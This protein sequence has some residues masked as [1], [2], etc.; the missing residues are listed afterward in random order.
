MAFDDDDEV[1][2]FEDPEDVELLMETGRKDEDIYDDKG[3]EQLVED[4]EIEGWEEGFMKGAEG[5]GQDAKCRKCGKVL[6]GPEE[7]VEKKIRGHILRFCS[8]LCGDAYEEEVDEHL[9]Q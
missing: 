5:G 3:R 7:I 9:D 6:M 4:D 2:D 1:V 8:E